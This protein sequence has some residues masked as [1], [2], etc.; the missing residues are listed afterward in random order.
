MDTQCQAIGINLSLLSPEKLNSRNKFDFLYCEKMIKFQKLPRGTKNKVL[1]TK[2]DLFVQ[3]T[4]ATK[5]LFSKAEVYINPNIKMFTIL[6][7]H[8]FQEVAT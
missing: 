4:K 6:G 7:N 3:G 8:Y 5:R 1:R 2:S